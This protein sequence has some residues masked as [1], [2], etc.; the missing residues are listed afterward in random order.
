MRRIDFSWQIV[1]VAFV[2]AMYGWGIGFYGL[3]VFIH[4]LQQSHGW[5]AGSVSMAVTGHYLV[6]ALLVVFVTDLQRRWG[7]APVLRLAV[8]LSGLGVIIW[9]AASQPWHLIPATILTAAGW[10]AMNT[11]TIAAIIHPWFRPDQQPHAL[12]MS[13]NG[14]SAGGIIFV[15]LWVALIDMSGFQMA[16]MM[17]A[18][19]M[20][21]VIFPL[22]VTHLSR[23]GNT[24]AAVPDQLGA[25]IQP[26]WS[27][28]RLLCDPRFFTMCCTFSLGLFV[29]VGTF[30]HLLIRLAPDMGTQAASVAMSVTAVSAILGRFALAAVLQVMHRRTAAAVNFAIQIAGLLLL[31]F[32]SQVWVLFVG[33]F[34]F[35][36]AVGNII[37]LPPLIA[38][39]EFPGA[40][41]ARAMA[42]STGISQAVFAFAPA[43]FGLLYDQFSS[44]TPG[45]VVSAATQAVAALIILAGRWKPPHRP[46]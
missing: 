41:G 1:A 19:S 43:F 38:Q 12:S 8:L 4:A 40:N 31:A 30:A 34:L 17:V 11:V 39:A 42:L 24:A 36:F 35:G 13:L 9:G 26:V 10:S 21:L 22:S 32:A 16:T 3:P 6:S 25:S 15:P 20:V 5:S 14:A 29:Q 33:C 28:K 18:A 23:P 2:V 44:F 7:L 37:T 45:L 46:G 27:R